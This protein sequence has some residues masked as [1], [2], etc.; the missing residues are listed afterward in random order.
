MVEGRRC[1]RPGPLARQYIDID[2]FDGRGDRR[3][4]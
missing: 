3:G 1:L 2:I 4:R